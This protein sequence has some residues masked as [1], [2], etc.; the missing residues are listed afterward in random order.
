[1]II[2]YAAAAACILKILLST[3]YLFLRRRRNTL[4]GL[5][6]PIKF[7]VSDVDS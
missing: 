1:M 6:R 2:K 4:S 7:W 5:G 3:H